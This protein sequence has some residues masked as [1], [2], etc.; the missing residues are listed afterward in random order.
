MI[1]FFQRITLRHLVVLSLI[2]NVTM[3][4]AIRPWNKDVEKNIIVTSDAIGYQQLAENILHYHSF[5]GT[6]DTASIPLNSR[7][8]KPGNLILNYDTYR[9]PGYPV[10]LALVYFIAGI[11]PYIAILIQLLL[12]TISVIL[13]YRIAQSLFNNKVVATIAALLFAIDIHSIYVANVL[14]SDTLFI[15]LFLLS[16][17]YFF[18]G[19]KAMSFLKFILSALFMGMAS[20]T[21]PVSLLY[22]FVLF[23]VVLLFNRGIQRKWFIKAIIPYTLIVYAI[24][25]GWVLRNHTTYNRWQLT[26]MD[27]YNLLDFNVAFTESRKAN[28]PIEIVRGTLLNMAIPWDV[29]G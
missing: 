3:Y 29:Y 21:R 5:Q 28:L 6:S 13:I 15:F 18:A 8:L 10:F 23:F 17:Y 27:G 25:G 14:Y 26:T 16:L 24:V 4:C 11:K 1:N 2:L 12:N 22:P 19:M 9:E 7:R 20:V